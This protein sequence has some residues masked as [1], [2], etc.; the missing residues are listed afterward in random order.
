MKRLGV[1]AFIVMGCLGTPAVAQEDGLLRETIE[2]TFVGAFSA[3]HITPERLSKEFIAW[4]EAT[5]AA[6]YDTLAKSLC[7]TAIMVGHQAD[8]H[9]S[10]EVY[11]QMYERFPEVEALP[12]IVAWTRLEQRGDAEGALEILK[13]RE[14]RSVA[15][16]DTLAWAQFKV[17]RK[18]DAMQTVLSTVR[19]AREEEVSEPTLFDHAGDILY[20]N[21]HYREA[22]H[23][24]RQG[25]R[26]AKSLIYLQQATEAELWGNYN[27][28]I[29]HSKRKRSAVKKLHP[30]AFAEG[31]ESESL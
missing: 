29:E 23:L 8:M 11:A 3:A 12:N 5:Q 26:A 17:G 27:Y 9:V 6:G 20:A 25:E 2:A 13:G 19:L 10:T 21:G 16:W 15:E 1:L 24:W 4:A 22:Y 14:E 28:T 30:E 7:M 18:V 31:A